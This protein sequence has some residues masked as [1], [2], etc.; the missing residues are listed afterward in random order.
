VP[1]RNTFL[2]FRLVLSNYTN[3]YR[4]ALSFLFDFV[5]RILPSY[6]YY[7]NLLS[8]ALFTLIMAI[9]WKPLVYRCRSNLRVQK[10]LAASVLNCG[11]RKIWL[12]PNESPEI[13]NANSR[14]SSIAFVLY[15]HDVLLLHLGSLLFGLIMLSLFHFNVSFD[16]YF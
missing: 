11:K 1:I 12:D 5:I 13:G 14:T 2:L 10:R 7:P 3:V 9:C 15:L 4:L 16:I 6:L 8:C